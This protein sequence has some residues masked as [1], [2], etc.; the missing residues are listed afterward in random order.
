MK[1]NEQRQT[2]KMSEV[3]KTFGLRERAWEGSDILAATA[4]RR[5]VGCGLHG[6]FPEGKIA[7]KSD[8][9]RETERRMLVLLFSF[10]H[11]VVEVVER[12][13]FER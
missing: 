5:E 8:W 11:F 1:E 2:I 13:P 12:F 3:R 6:M 9:L 7:S 10:P 4:S